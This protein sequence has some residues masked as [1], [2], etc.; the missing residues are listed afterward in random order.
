[1][2]SQSREPFVQ[3]GGPHACEL[4][5]AHKSNFQSW[6]DLSVF[7]SLLLLFLISSLLTGLSLPGPRLSLH[8][9]G[10]P[11]C[12]LGDIG[13][14]NGV[15]G[16]QRLLLTPTQIFPVGDP[17]HSYFPFLTSVSSTLTN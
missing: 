4:C 6:G 5:L 7:I 9:H 1:M 15:S 13:Y 10:L 12:T 3:L 2:S 11:S 17:C 8:H 16:T 14:L